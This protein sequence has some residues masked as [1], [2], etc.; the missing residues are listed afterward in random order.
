MHTGVIFLRDPEEVFSQ[1]NSSVNVKYYHACIEFE[2]I[3]FFF[4]V[5]NIYFR[6]DSP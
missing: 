1:L 4:P 5:F 6:V 2:G 3:K